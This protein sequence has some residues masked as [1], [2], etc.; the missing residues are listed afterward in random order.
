MISILVQAIQRRK[1]H[2]QTQSSL[3]NILLAAMQ[4]Q[5]CKLNI[6]TAW[7]TLQVVGSCGQTAEGYKLKALQFLVYPI[8][9][10]IAISSQSLAS[11]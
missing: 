11:S 1:D 9:N 2:M 10:A 5:H 6:L 8:L 7:L 4:N 3:L